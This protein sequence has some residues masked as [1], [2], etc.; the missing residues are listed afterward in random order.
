MSIYITGVSYERVNQ[1][2]CR[3]THHK[4]DVIKIIINE[5]LIRFARNHRFLI[6][7]L[8]IYSD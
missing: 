8:E 6:V 5:L 3:N 1:K 2:R 7:N 4:T